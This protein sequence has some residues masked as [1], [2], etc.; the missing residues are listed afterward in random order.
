LYFLHF[1]FKGIKMRKALFLLLSCIVVQSSVN[2]MG[3][4]PLHKAAIRGDVEEVRR[5]LELGAEV[6]LD[7][8]GWTPL[9]YAAIHGHETVARLLLEKGANPNLKSGYGY[10]PLYLAVFHRHETVARLLLERH[11]NPYLE[12][13][14]GAGTPLDVATRKGYAAIVHMIKKQP[15]HVL[16]MAMHPRMGAHSPASICDSHVLRII[17]GYLIEQ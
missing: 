9:E 6:N 1:N 10:R 3:T 2:G 17:C 5:L 14:S 13:Y 11:A 7:Y 12:D 8:G 16:A 4:T 15:V